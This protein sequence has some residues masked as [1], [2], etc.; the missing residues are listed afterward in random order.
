MQS[1][2]NKIGKLLEDTQAGYSFVSKKFRPP[3]HGAR[4]QLSLHKLGTLSSSFLHAPLTKL[5]ILPF[6]HAPFFFFVGHHVGHPY[7]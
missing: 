3:C 1:S 6:L 7:A 4:E 5:G 2:Q